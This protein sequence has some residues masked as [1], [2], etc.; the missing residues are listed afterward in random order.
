MWVILK[1]KN[2]SIETLKKEFSK[3][4]G[5]DYIMNKIVNSDTKAPYIILFII[6]VL[7]IHPFFYMR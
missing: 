1:F 6:T 3:V 2:K 7:S 5:K 4:L